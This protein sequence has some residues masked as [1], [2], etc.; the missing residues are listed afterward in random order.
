MSDADRPFRIPQSTLYAPEAEEFD[1]YDWTDLPYY[2][3]FRGSFHK[4]P[5]AIDE[6]DVRAAGADVAIV[7][8]P[9]DESVS[10]RP[11]ARMGPKAIRSDQASWLPRT[12]GATRT[13][14]RSSWISS[15]SSRSRSST[16]ATRRWCRAG[17]NAASG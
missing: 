13:P 1:E 3:D 5:W 16:R 9:Y 2:A 10:A 15:R 11:G 14:G 8:A 6:A 17:P 7:G 12:T 4:F